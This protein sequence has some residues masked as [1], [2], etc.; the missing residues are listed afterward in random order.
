MYIM[1][2]V[3]LYWV[4]LNVLIEFDGIIVVRFLVAVVVIK[5]NAKQ[6]S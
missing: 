1:T 2:L 6:L 3:P 5:A 4:C